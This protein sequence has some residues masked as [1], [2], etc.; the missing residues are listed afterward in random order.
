MKVPEPKKRPSGAWRLQLRLDGVSI[1]ITA[2]SAK[3]CKRQ[4]ALIKAEHLAGRRRVTRSDL[5]L[6]EACRR[7]IAAGER[8]GR[9]PETIRGYDIITRCR[10]QSVMDLPVSAVTNWQRVYDEDAAGHSA[11][12]MENAWRFIRSACRHECHIELPEIEL[13][14]PDRTEHLFLEPDQIRRFV[15]AAAGDRHQIPLLLLLHSCRS[16]EI[17]GL[18]WANVDLAAGRI[19]IAETLVQDKARRYVQK[20][21]TKTDE[22]TRYIPIFIPELRAALEAV[23]DK[24]G[25]VVAVRPN[26]VY[27]RANKICEEL[28]LPLVGQ[29]GLRHSFASLCFSLEVPIK[30]TMALGGWKND[31]T[32]SEIYTHLSQKHVDR[33]IQQLQAFFGA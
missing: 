13:K 14:A 11:K 28:G 6:R 30:I 16:S 31:R 5:T 10:F 3:E 22:S 15:A 7:Y 32:V 2:A 19:R 21:R 29:H 27:R 1:P 8:A 26:T 12:T 25:K 9:S 20:P 24:T 33:H 17:Q 23:E 18:D 4:A